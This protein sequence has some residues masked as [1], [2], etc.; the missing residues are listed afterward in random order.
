MSGGL[1]RRLDQGAETGVRPVVV[2]QQVRTHP[3]VHNTLIVGI[4]RE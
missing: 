1:R 2:K 4:E 3:Q